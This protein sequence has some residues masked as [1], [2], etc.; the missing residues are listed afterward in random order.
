MVDGTSRDGP[1]SGPARKMFRAARGIKTNNNNNNIAFQLLI[2]QLERAEDDKD[3]LR[4]NN[5]RCFDE[6]AEYHR[7]LEKKVGIMKLALPAKFIVMRQIK[8]HSNPRHSAISSQQTARKYSDT[9]TQ[10]L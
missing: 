9:H 2:S 10:N 5:A 7:A 1:S 8:R 6:L 3:E 4:T